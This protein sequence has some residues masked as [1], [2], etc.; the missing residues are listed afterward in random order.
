MACDCSGRHELD[1]APNATPRTSP[2]IGTCANFSFSGQVPGSI[3][4]ALGRSRMISKIGPFRL[5]F[6]GPCILS[7]E[8]TGSDARCREELIAISARRAKV[9]SLSAEIRGR[10]TKPYRLP[11]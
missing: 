11:H 3:A 8:V 4:L 5:I 9:L 2:A 6:E 7:A 1:L 10:K